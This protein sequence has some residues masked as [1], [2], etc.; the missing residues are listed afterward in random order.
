[1]AVSRATFL[2]RRPEFATTPTTLVD[3]CLVDAELMIDRDVY[4]GKADAGVMAYAAHLIAI[5]PLGEMARLDKKGEKT[6]YFLE[7]ERIKR[8]LGVGYRVI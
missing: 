7:W 5:N 8:S 1:V 3:A 6:T 4:G 2:S